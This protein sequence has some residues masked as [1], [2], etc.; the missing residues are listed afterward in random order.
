M[1]R[2][3]KLWLLVR[4]FVAA[5]PLWAEALTVKVFRRRSPR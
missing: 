4:D 3:H 5:L 1:T 2:L